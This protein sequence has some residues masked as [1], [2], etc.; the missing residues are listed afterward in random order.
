[1]SLISAGTEKM[2]IEFSQASLVQKARQQPERVKQVLDK[3]KT[4]GFLPTLE[5]VFRK[6]DTPLPLGYCNTGRV[7]EVGT[8]V[9]GI[10]PGDRV[11]S[12][13]PHAEVV[14]VPEH[15]CAK[16]P[17]AVPNERAS[18]T[19]LSSIALQ[20][21]RLAEPTLG[22]KFIVVGMGLLGLLTVQLLK[23]SGCQVLAVDINPERLQLAGK[24]GA[25]MIDVHSASKF[26][27][28][29]I[30]WTE[31]HGVDGVI[32]SASSKS[33]DIIHQSA[34]ACRKRGRIILV[35]VVGLEIQR[36]DFY[37]KELRFQ[38]SCSY[39]PGR[40]DE[41]YEKQGVDYPIG[42]VRWTE[43]RNFQAV[44][45]LMCQ[46]MLYPEQLITSRFPIGD[47]VKAY[48][49]LQTDSN[50]L[51]VLLTYPKAS[52]DTFRRVIKI[53][54][55]TPKAVPLTLGIIGAGS[56]AG[57][58]F[59]PELVKTSARIKTIAD[60]NPANASHLA[61]KFAVEQT[62]T[63][64]KSILNDPDITAV[65]ILV[66]HHL[67]APFVCETLRAGKHVFVEKP[68]AITYEQLKS[69][70]KLM[71][72]CNMQLM[73][74]FN[75]RF[76]PHTQKIRY[77]LQNRKEPLCMNATINA[78]SI[79]A[80]HWIQD[81]ERGGGRIIGEGCHFIDLLSYIAQSPVSRVH[82][83]QI[84][85][86]SA[87]QS[88]KTAISLLFR[89]GSIGTINYFSNGSKQYPKETIEI[90]N[91][92]KVL[93]LENFRIVRGYGFQGF[94][95]FKTTRQDKGH[96]TEIGAFTTSIVEGGAPLIPFDQLY[97]VTYASIAAAESAIVSEIKEIP[98]LIDEI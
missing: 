80:D 65:I 88:D 25:D 67:H 46:G 32:I 12:N 68:L 27:D 89:D 61:K 36:A 51:G 82:S 8:G 21:I 70:R 19:V 60:L 37:E 5:A 63:D 90:F 97:N 74:G 50:A 28:S 92:N 40:Y 72:G 39:G 87:I 54:T 66:G 95:T 79:P 69:V 15:L 62:T 16:I 93:R 58:V 43:Q 77:L 55:Q 45:E 47:A 44:L 24:Y 35:G 94:K 13:G 7:V 4:D 49:T 41:R 17:D 18:F 42:F 23:V 83:V 78:G 96:S 34:L 76:S 26:A 59:L 75:R 86:G 81:T 84:G 38:V 85:S 56:F 48:E 33:N 91:Q 52:A 14:C 1:V 30:S 11:A 71:D 53:S 22:E 31:G 73:V 6:L 3:M 10:H 57:N 9:T 98:H 2:L 20:G 29:A 64:Y